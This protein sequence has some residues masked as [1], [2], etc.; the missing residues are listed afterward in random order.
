MKVIL[1]YREHLRVIKLGILMQIHIFTRNG[2]YGNYNESGM[3]F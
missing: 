1:R 3:K 2:N